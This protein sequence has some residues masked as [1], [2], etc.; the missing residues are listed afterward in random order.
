ML[1]NAIVN[2]M[3]IYAM[4]AVV[5]VKMDVKQVGGAILETFMTATNNVQHAYKTSASK[6]MAFVRM[7]VYQATMGQ[8]V[9]NSVHVSRVSHV[10]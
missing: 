5:H 8:L 10:M 7:D 3:V 4:W 6:T 2:V 9:T 1:F